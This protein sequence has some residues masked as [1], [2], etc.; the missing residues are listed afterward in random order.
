MRLLFVHDHRFVRG[1]NGLL[2]T[3]GGF[4]AFVWERYLR[5]FDEV[6]VLARDGG[7][8]PPGADL[9]L[10]SHPDVS[11]EFA[12]NMASARQLL[13]PSREAQEKMRA[14]VER[15]DA[16]VARLPSELGFLAVKTARKLGKPYSVEVVACAWDALFNYGLLKY[17]LYAPLFFYRARRAMRS[18]P[19]ALYVTSKWLQTRYPTRGFWTSASNVE[20]VRMDEEGRARRARRIEEIANGRPPR[21]GTVASLQNRYKGIQTA[22]AALALLKKEGLELQYEVLGPGDPKPFQQLAAE[23]GVGH[24]VTF[25]GTRSAGAGVRDWLDTID[26]YLQP[27]FQ[28]GLPRAT[29]EAMSRGLACIGSTAGGIPELLSPETTHRPGDA[30]GLAD[31][32]RRLASDP[33]EIAR[34]SET[35]LARAEDYSPDRLVA[36]RDEIYSRLRAAAE[37]GRQAAA[38]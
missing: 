2:Y 16:V 33:Q 20:M 23:A 21:L 22:I 29:V 35:A 25:A 19:L 26:I 34:A 36:R 31:R 13:K 32:M 24:L 6:L 30:K 5:H 9:A 8:L 27:S 28:E 38:A 10:A 3:G 15:S 7:E 1:E 18:A 14:A 12:P 17:R 37:R 11:F 4:P